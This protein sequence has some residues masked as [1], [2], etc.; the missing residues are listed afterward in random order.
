[1][2]ALGELSSILVLLNF[3]AAAAARGGIEKAIEDVE[4]RVRADFSGFPPHTHE[5]YKEQLAKD[6]EALKQLQKL[7]ALLHGRVFQAYAEEQK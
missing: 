5:Y 3:S 7:R 2:A 1:M 6:K 4:R